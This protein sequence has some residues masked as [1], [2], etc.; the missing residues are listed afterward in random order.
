MISC[1][2]YF[3]KQLIKPTTMKFK[4]HRQLYFQVLMSIFI[5]ILFGHFFPDLAVK[6]KPLGDTFIRLIKMM[7]P[8]IVFTTVVT[9]IA[10]MNNMRAAGRIGI[11]ALIYFEVVTTL[12]MIIGLLVANYYQPGTGLNINIQSLNHATIDTLVH[13]ASFG[14]PNI[15]PDSLIS[16]FVK[17]DILPVLFVSILSGFGLLHAGEKANP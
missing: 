14:L 1:R 6:M 3:S 16:A 2:I 11:K 15:I 9:G 17:G 7:L 12:A 4:L 8:P 10:G 5:G 13:P